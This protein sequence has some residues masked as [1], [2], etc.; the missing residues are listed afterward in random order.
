MKLTKSSLLE[1]IKEVVSENQSSVL[2]HD[3]KG[4]RPKKYG[5]FKRVMQIIGPSEESFKGFGV[6]SAENPLGQKSSSFDNQKRME[7]L[8]QTLR[9]Q[10]KKYEEV[11]GKF[12]NND[13]NSLVISDIDVRTMASLSSHK[14]W[15]QHSFIFGKKSKIGDDIEVDYYM[16]ELRYDD[17]YEMAGW[18]ITDQ[19]T[20]FFTNG[21]IQKRKDMFSKVGGKKFYIPFFDDDPTI[22][23]EPNI[24]PVGAPPNPTN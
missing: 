15:P 5:K 23:G 16:I 21:E 3:A 8:K 6:M 1:I 17:S 22:G 2:L 19:R 13:E 14:D 4:P 24:P 11:Q 9:R 10:G 12:F 7:Q 20:S 18:E